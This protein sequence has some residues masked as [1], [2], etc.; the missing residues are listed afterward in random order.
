VVE[1]N[2][3]LA[4][5]LFIKGNDAS[6]N[7]DYKTAINY[8]RQ[9]VELQPEENYLAIKLASDLIR[10]GQLHEGEKILEKAY[11]QSKNEDDAVGVILAG[12]Y[13][14]R[15][16]TEMARVIYKRI[17]KTSKEI[18]D[19]C[20][21]LAKDLAF[22][23]KYDQAHALLLNCEKK[24]KDVPVYSF[25]R[26]KIEFERGHQKLSES[27]LRHSLKVD[28][29][30]YQAALVLGSLYEKKSD[31]KSAVKIYKQFIENTGNGTNV[32]VL[33]RL[34][35]LLFLIK[36]NMAA[37]PYAERLCSLNKNCTR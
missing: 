27:F 34:V 18:E 6:I 21:F 25:Y 12:V 32:P 36:E 31:F 8:F 22:E 1:G 16:K 37:M 11:L 30:F 19:A 2:T 5:D 24:D 29:S 17:I 35:P 26:G 28:P 23:K 10:D 14:A 9:L 15:E 13:I 3:F 4:T 7:G 33:S 20:M